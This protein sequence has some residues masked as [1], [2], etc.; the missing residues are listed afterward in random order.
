MCAALVQNSVL[1][2]FD[3]SAI[4]LESEDVVYSE[5][6]I[7][8]RR[9]R[10]RWSNRSPRLRDVDV[11]INVYEL[12]PSTLV[13]RTSLTVT[14][15]SA[16]WQSLNV[17]DLVSTCVDALRDRNTPPRMIAISFAV[18]VRFFS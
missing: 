16:G 13:Q 14:G 11:A 6:H 1:Y 17:T 18:T 12:R 3:V 4:S 9:R 8:K 15:R 10:S 5:I 7:Y 2:V